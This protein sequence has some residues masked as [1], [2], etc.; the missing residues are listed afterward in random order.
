[1]RPALTSHQAATFLRVYA[2]AVKGGP[3][4][5]LNTPERQALEALQQIAAGTRHKPGPRP[6][7]AAW[8]DA[9]IPFANGTPVSFRSFGR[10]GLTPSRRG[11]VVDARRGPKGVFLAIAEEGT[12]PGVVVWCRAALIQPQEESSED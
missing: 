11:I 2:R 6:A 12:A 3:Q 7:R 4:R 8:E 5:P 1:M 10:H 9:P